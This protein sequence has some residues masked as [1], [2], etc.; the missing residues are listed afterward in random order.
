M[1]G[2][3]LIDPCGNYNIKTQ[4]LAVFIKSIIN[5]ESIKNKNNIRAA[6]VKEYANEINALH[7]LRNLEPPIVF[8][9]KTNQLATL[10]SNLEREED[11]AKQRKPI[12]KQMA[13][14]MIKRGQNAPF[15]S[16]ESL[17]RNTIIIARKI[18][19]R[20]GEFTQKS[21][22]KPDYH[23]YQSGKRLIKSICA[24]WLIF[25]N[26]RGNKIKNPSRTRASV[27]SVAIKWKIQ[28]NRRNGEELLYTRDYNNPELCMVESCIDLFK[29]A[30]T[31]GQDTDLPLFVYEDKE[32][33]M[34]YL[35][36][37]A[38]TKYIQTAAIAAH[39]DLTKSELSYYSCHSLRVW[40]AVLLN[41][42]GEDGDVIRIQ[43]RWLSD[44]YRVYLRNTETRADLHNQ[45]LDNNS[46]EI[47]F[48]L[49]HGD[50][51]NVNDA[52]VTIDEEMADSLDDA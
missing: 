22:N 26:R 42:A 14:E 44:A 9:D 18:G 15:T 3:G 7:I 12:T 11:I 29:R 10:I 8:A 35:T 43:L 37:N 49:T 41:E 21:A 39:P 38:T 17:L 50:L 16:K 6:T 5:G 28:K 34:K 52:A 45:A 48:E 27:H 25:R 51:A 1:R 32:G 23:E 4:I 46:K 36:A 20:A 13:A 19:P 40:A 2:Y 31:L 24:D 47:T 30:A 33:T